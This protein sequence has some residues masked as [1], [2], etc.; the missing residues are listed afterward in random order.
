MAPS[1]LFSSILSF[2]W[3]DTVHFYKQ[4]YIQRCTITVY[5][6]ITEVVKRENIQKCAHV[7]LAHFG[8]LPAR[9]SLDLNFLRPLGYKPHFH[10]WQPIPTLPIP[11]V[12]TS[13]PVFT[14]CLVHTELSTLDTL[15]KPGSDK[16]H[17]KCSS[18]WPPSSRRLG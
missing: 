15:K 11:S 13:I 9:L 3:H 14:S 4:V 7:Y 6:D 1:N 2:I 17:P 12:I 18:G 16:L 10:N 5:F 8:V